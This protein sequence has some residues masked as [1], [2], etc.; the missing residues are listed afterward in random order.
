MT[1]NFEIQ[2]SLRLI[3]T[4][5]LHMAIDGS[6]LLADGV[7]NAGLAAL[8]PAIA[9]A[10]AEVKHSLLFDIGDAFQGSAL[11]DDLEPDAAHPMQQAFDM[12]GYDAQTLGNH[13]LDFGLDALEHVLQGGRIPMVCANLLCPMGQPVFDPYRILEVPFNDTILRV[14]ITGVVPPRVMRWNGHHLRTRVRVSDSVDAVRGVLPELRAAG[15]DIVV[16]LAHS[17][18]VP[19]DH[20]DLDEQA[21]LPIAN[22]DGVDVVLCGHQHRVFPGPDFPPADGIDPIAG[23]LNGTPAIMAGSSG[24]RIGV[25][26]LS[27]AHDGKCWS[28]CAHRASFRRAAPQRDPAIAAIAAPHVARTRARLAEPISSTPYPLCTVFAAMADSRAVRAVQAAFLDAGRRAL[29]TELPLLAV[30]SPYR[31]GGRS[32]PEAY[33]SLPAGTL[34]HSAISD[35]CPFANRI[36]AVEATGA[37]MIDWLE[38]A[39]LHLGH[40]HSDQPTQPL[41]NPEMPGYNFDAALGLT[42]RID[43]T[44]PPRFTV[45]GALIDPSARRIVDIHHD[46]A[47]LDPAKRFAVITS[48][49]RVSGGGNFPGLSDLRIL[50]DGIGTMSDLVTRWI[51]ASPDGIEVPPPS[52]QL[53]PSS[54][55]RATYRTGA[56]RPSQDV[57]PHQLVSAG[58]TAEGWHD[59]DVTLNPLED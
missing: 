58:V 39:S 17:G 33:T 15:A 2:G 54:T 13:D 9:A 28:V 30:S 38:M 16:V 19:I 21:A 55:V 56:G 8:A 34:H 43:P 36:I 3:C 11:T 51:S 1:R 32:G 5:D 48:S 29:D 45:S 37:Q 41:I 20:A 53:S 4:T 49:Y 50:H 23:T 12:L 57:L 52:W 24:Q 47:P 42:Y 31:T 25:L 26:D 14:G 22:L 18:I 7:D 10:R 59:W 40:L 46:G 44:Q 27:L 35:L 6:R